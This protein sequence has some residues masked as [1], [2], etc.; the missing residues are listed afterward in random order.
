MQR[1]NR[2]DAK[3]KKKLNTKQRRREEE[4]NTEEMSAETQRRREEQFSSLRLCVS[5]FI[6]SSC[7]RCFVFNLRWIG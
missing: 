4:E 5:V 6:S 2:E 3:K 1:V 7:L